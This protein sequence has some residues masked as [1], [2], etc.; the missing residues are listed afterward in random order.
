MRVPLSWLRDFID[1]DESVDELRAVFDDLGLVVEGIEVVG[2]GLDDVVVARVLGIDAIPGADKIRLVHV[3]AGADPVDVVCGAWNFDV[4]DLVPFAPVGAT[5][6][7]GLAIGRKSLRG[8]TSHG[9]L[10]SPRELRLADDHQGLMILDSGLGGRIGDPLVDALGLAPDVVF[11]LTVEGNR[12]DAWCVAG[13]A[14]DLGARLGRAVRTPAVEAPSDAGPTKGVA[15][16]RLDAPDLCGRLTV[17]ALTGVAVAPSPGWVARRLTYAG[18]RP[19]NNVVDASNLVMLELGQ[20]THPYDAAL[21]AGSTIGVRAAAAGERLTTLDGAERILG[22]AGRGLGDTGV[23][24]VIVDGNDEAIGLAGIMGGASSEIS[25]T[26]TDVLVEA[27]WFDPMTV[28]RSSRRHGLRTEASARF[29]RGVDPTLPLR[30]VGRLVAVLR[31]TSPGLAWLAD[32][33]DERGSLP[34]P[35]TIELTED[36]VERALGSRVEREEYE[37]GLAALGFSVERDGDV[38]RVTAPPSRPDVRAGVAG[39]ADVIE[40]V[41][42]LHGYRRL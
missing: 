15:S 30:A 14:R 21:V 10:C 12:P 19:I 18:M 13:V 20:P 37:A 42:R 4:D 24:A 26:T 23:D 40:E 36:D 7:G 22:V 9:M 32:P 3:D 8:V 6:P 35:P 16:A 11:D 27:A 38:A 31:E 39:R 5:L 25:A 34:V 33:L 2:E 28:A 1:L 41:A 17:S 29:E